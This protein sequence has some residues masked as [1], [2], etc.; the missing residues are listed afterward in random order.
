MQLPETCLRGIREW[1]ARTDSILEVWLFGSRASDR[2]T[3][4]SDVDLA[5]VLMPPKPSSLPGGQPHDWAF[6]NYCALGDSWQSE[7]AA[8]VGRHVSLEVIRPDHPDSYDM[9]RTNG[10]LLWAR[11]QL[12]EGRQ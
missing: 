10:A 6:R 11:S 2:A 9:V 4:E 8:I 1:A 3:S 12:G 7:L 5:I